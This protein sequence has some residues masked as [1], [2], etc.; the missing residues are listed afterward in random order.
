MG[1]LV[2][3]PSYL[4]EDEACRAG[5]VVLSPYLQD[6]ACLVALF[7]SCHEEEAYLEVDLVL[8]YHHEEEAYPCLNHGNEACRDCHLGGD[9][10]YWGEVDSSEGA[11]F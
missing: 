8:S 11:H 9:Y 5:L 6:E 1:L 3:S 4:E 7:P 10:P 2:L